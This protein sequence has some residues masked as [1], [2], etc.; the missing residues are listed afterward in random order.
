MFIII[1]KQ[2]L[3]LVFFI[4]F[5]SS[6]GYSDSQIRIKKLID[7]YKMKDNMV[8]SLLERSIKHIIIF[9]LVLSS[10]VYLKYSNFE[11]TSKPIEHEKAGHFLM[12]TVIPGYEELNIMGRKPYVN[13]Y[14]DSK[15][16]MI[17]YAPAADVLYFAKLHKVDY[18]VVDD[19]SLGKWDFYDELIGMHELSVDV[20]LVYEDD[21]EYPIRLFKINY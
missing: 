12:E 6:A 13:F 14:T 16:T 9:L 19:R 11:N 1:E 4:I 17:P 10:L 15:F 5:I 21:S 2:T 3:I 18:I 20:S 8:L 7:H